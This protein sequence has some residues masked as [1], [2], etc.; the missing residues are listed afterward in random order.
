M[1]SPYTKKYRSESRVPLEKKERGV[2]YAGG[3]EGG[4]SNGLR[5]QE[6]VGFI[7]NRGKRKR[8]EHVPDSLVGPQIWICHR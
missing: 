4:K 3:G 5:E 2:G 7:S 6:R 1:S 8:K